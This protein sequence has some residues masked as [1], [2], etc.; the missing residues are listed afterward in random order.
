VFDVTVKGKTV[1]VINDVGLEAY[2]RGVVSQE[3]PHD[4][5]LEAVKAQAVAARSFALSQKRGAEFDV[6]A[7]VRDQVY[8][9]VEAETPVGNRASLETKGRVLM[10]NGKVATTFF[11]SSSGGRT[12]SVEDVFFGSTPVP[13]LVSV[14]DPYDT[15]SP[16]HTWGPVVLTATAISKQLQVAGVSELRPIPATGRARSVVITGK[17]G[18]FVLPASSVRRS[19]DLRS[20]WFRPGVLVLTATGTTLT[21]SVR[22]AEGVVLEQRVQGGAWVQGPP[23]ELQPDGSFEL[24]VAPEGTTMYRLAAGVAKGAPVRVSSS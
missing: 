22:R 1:F 16:Y 12:A 4:W 20:T 9:G 17:N 23:L 13:Y 24:T 15:V 2:V 10:Y 18:D 14:P 6:Y 11:F 21:G 8:G 7:D 3:M 19:L 5:P